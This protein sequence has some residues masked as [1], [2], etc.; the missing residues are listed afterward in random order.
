MGCRVVVKK[1]SPKVKKKRKFLI[2]TSGPYKIQIPT[3]DQ[4]LS[5]KLWLPVES[6]C[7]R[8]ELTTTTERI[9]SN[10]WF[11]VI[12]R[13]TDPII[14]P[15]IT[16]SLQECYQLDDNREVIPIFEP[17][18][19]KKPVDVFRIKRYRLNLSKRN[20]TIWMDWFH[21]CRYLY[22]R[23]VSWY[24]AHQTILNDYM[25]D[26]NKSPKSTWTFKVNKMSQYLLQLLRTNLVTS[27][28]ADQ[29][30][31]RITSGVAYNVRYGVVG[32]FVT[33]YKTRLKLGKPFVMHYNKRKWQHSIPIRAKDIKHEGG[34]E[35]TFGNKTISSLWCY[36]NLFGGKT[37]N[38]LCCKKEIGSVGHDS[39]LIW[40]GRDLFE[41][42]VPYI[43]KPPPFKEITG[44]ACAIDPGTTPFQAVYGSDGVAYSIGNETLDDQVLKAQRLRNISGRYKRNTR[45]NLLKKAARIEQKIQYKIGDIHH[46]LAKFLTIK[47]DT[48]IIPNFK[49]KQMTSDDT[50]LSS[51]TNRKL[52]RWGHYAFRSL[53]I[54]K[55]VKHGCKVFVGTEEY[56]SKTCG[57]CFN[58][59]WG[60]KGNKVY[61]CS[62]CGLVFDR[63]INAARNI[64]MLNWNRFQYSTR[65]A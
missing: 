7:K 10:S 6:N 42:H 56:T 45:R 40:D 17:V 46:K 57:N 44:L 31:L 49:V 55:G 3:W 15:N 36:V 28:T 18:D 4:D 52:Y 8:A 11:S 26:L 53:L 35:V 30:V 20:K 60:L 41:L 22:N 38:N 37:R 29:E 54:T 5:D 12:K 51:A 33:A 65:V 16:S 2:K 9:M 34:D 27:T 43:I 39:N 24:Y 61:S 19:P 64:L 32:D 14:Q 21:K 47:Y 62:E 50:R 13:S 58:I 63:D 59:D 1:P 48:I 25:N 23:C